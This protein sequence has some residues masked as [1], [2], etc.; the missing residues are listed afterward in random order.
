MG[1]CSFLGAPRSMRERVDERKREIASVNRRLERDA[2][3]L[4][5][6]EED[7][8]RAMLEHAQNG[9]LDLAEGSALRVVRLRRQQADNAATQGAV[10]EVDTLVTHVG[11]QAALG[12][13]FQGVGRTVRQ[14]W[15]VVSA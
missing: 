10:E 8:R 15:V 11:D 7:A 12:R 2:D 6:K 13:V 14:V 1:S 9:R 4:G 5:V 3:D